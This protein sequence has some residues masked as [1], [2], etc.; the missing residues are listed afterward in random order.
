MTNTETS[1]KREGVKLYEV[2]YLLLPTIAEEKLQ[3]EIDGIKSVIE[4]AGGVFVSEGSP[5]T[6]V[7]TYP[8]E[9]AIS[10]KK[11]KFETASFGWVKFE[12]EAERINEVKEKLD[13]LE[14]ILRYLLIITTKETTNAKARKF[15]FDQENKKDTKEV[16]D[17]EEVKKEALN[18]EKEEK[19]VD[20][21]VLDETI[22]DLVIE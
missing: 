18:E 13:K 7:L 2:G 10:G 12:A 21:K 14:N 1:L 22:D 19:K 17:T 4:G 6:K 8:M 9:K 15:S 3:L 5:Q 16:K 20:K 11:Q